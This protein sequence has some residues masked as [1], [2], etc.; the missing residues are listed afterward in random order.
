M[1][2]AVSLDWSL[3]VP[4]GRRNESAPRVTTSG[5]GGRAGWGV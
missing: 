5:G 1:T 2:E 4:H 3:V